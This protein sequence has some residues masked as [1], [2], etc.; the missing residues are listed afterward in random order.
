MLVLDC[1]AF[2]GQAGAS[3]R[4]ENY[5][6]FPT[7]ISGHGADGARLQPGAEVRRRDGDPGRGRAP[8]SVIRPPDGARFQ[9]GARERG[10]RQR[11]RG[12]DRER[13]PLPPPRRRRTSPSS[14]ARRVHYWASPLE[15]RLCAGQEVALVGAGNSAG[16]AVGVSRGARSRKVW[17]LVRGAE[18]RGEHV[19]LPRRPH[20]GAAER[21]GP[22]RRREVTRARRTAT[23]CWRRSAGAT[24][25]RARRRGGR[26][27]TS[28]SS[29]AP[30]RTPTGCRSRDVALDAKGFVRTG[31]DARRRPPAARDEPP[32]RLRDR[33]RARRLGEARRRRRRRGRAGGRGAARVPRRR[34]GDAGRRCRPGGPMA[35]ECRHVAGIRNVTPS[36]LGCEEC[37]KMRLA[38]GAPAPLPDVRPRR[39]LRQLAEP[40]RDE[41]LPRDRPSDHRGLRPAR[42]LGLVLRRRG[43]ARPRRPATPQ[44]GP[45]PALRLTPWRLC[46][47]PRSR[48]RAARR[49]A[50][51]RAAPAAL[52]AR[53]ARSRACASPA[54]RS[55][56]APPCARDARPGSRCAPPPKARCSFGLRADVEAIRIREPAGIAVR[57]VEHRPPRA[58][59]AG[60]VTPPNSASSCRMR[61]VAPIG[62]SKRRHSST[63][64]RDQLRLAA[65]PRELAGM[66][67]QLVDAVPDQADRGLEARDQQTDRLRPAA[68]CGERRSPASSA[69][70]RSESRSSREAPAARLD[71]LLEVERQI[72]RR[73]GEAALH[74]LRG[75]ELGGEQVGRVAGPAR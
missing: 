60:S 56:P 38:L 48:R 65:Q 31:A 37:L 18:P 59:P 20:R 8:A 9:L 25:R 40:P 74:D 10:A 54:R 6:G 28:S 57:G 30:I 68:R 4:I 22:D 19:A 70:I 16:Q 27:A 39:L 55:P 64:V 3:A 33:R 53:A 26:S 11:A 17:L 71:Q 35:D 51:Q 62:P 50:E 7:G 36:A 2:G 61:S 73:R 21:R 42:G 66:A 72:A 41:A 52:L 63:A 32:G 67:Q 14:R 49:H 43:D 12:R 46:A 24:R 69:R 29:S 58:C 45:I 13:R 23:A 44:S 1:R 34:R 15:A 47:R 5:L 75:R